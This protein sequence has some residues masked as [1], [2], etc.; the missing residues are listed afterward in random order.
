MGTYEENLLASLTYQNPTK[1]QYEAYKD[2]DVKINDFGEI[3]GSTGILFSPALNIV[4]PQDAQ[5][6]YYQQVYAQN[7][8]QNA[9]A[10]ID[11]GID[12]N[13]LIQNAIVKA[14]GNPVTASVPRVTVNPVTGK[15][16]VISGESGSS[17]FNPKMLMIAGLAL[18]A[19]M[20]LFKK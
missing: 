19:M 20:F 3:I 14:T 6:A 15:A 1:Y 5:Q 11:A 10:L 4:K 7:N 2:G 13:V 12:P 18:V 17:S 8:N 16:E 9:Q